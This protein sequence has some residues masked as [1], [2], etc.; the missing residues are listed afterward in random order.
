VGKAA[1][2]TQLHTLCAA[3]R[4]DAFGC[5]CLPLRIHHHLK[6]EFEVRF[7]DFSKHSQDFALFG[8]PFEIN[9]TDVPPDLQM[10]LIE[11]QCD[12]AQK[13]RFMAMGPVAFWKTQA[14]TYPSM[15][16]NAHKVAAFFGSTYCC[17][18]LFSR[19]KL[20]KLSTCSQLTDDHLQASLL[21]SVSSVK[22]DFKRLSASI[23][24]QPS[25]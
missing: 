13:S 14:A 5:V 18:Q 4:T 3:R 16:T 2:S 19:M 17:E 9:P 25:H 8:A 6:A 24:H 12:D 1:A 10:N 20:I 7:Q 23:N 21:L 22:P 15:A 11:L